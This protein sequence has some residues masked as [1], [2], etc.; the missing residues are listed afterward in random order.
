MG[1]ACSTYGKEA[2]LKHNCGC[3][4]W[5]EKTSWEDLGVGEA[6]VE[7]KEHGMWAGFLRP[8]IE[9]CD[10]LLRTFEFHKNVESFDHRSDY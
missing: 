9:T 5:A 6:L 7:F 1:G 8:S 2:K 4:I 3:K 10:K